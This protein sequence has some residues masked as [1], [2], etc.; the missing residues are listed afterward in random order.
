MAGHYYGDV[1]KVFLADGDAL[2]MPCEDLLVILQ[3]LYATFPSLE[4]VGIYASPD[5]I[6]GK[7][8]EELKQLRDAGI[9]IA[10]LGV[11]LCIR[12][13]APEESLF[14]NVCEGQSCHAPRMPA[15]IPVPH[16][17]V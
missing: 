8:P 5:S 4:H 2:A 14:R 12:L 16:D 17:S 11:G 6:L 15:R 3:A 1:L 9:T 10:Y 13:S 7:T